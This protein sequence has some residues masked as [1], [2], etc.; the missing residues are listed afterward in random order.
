MKGPGCRDEEE[1]IQEI[2]IPNYQL[3][4]TAAEGGKKE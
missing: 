4:I 3:P 1:G 2:P